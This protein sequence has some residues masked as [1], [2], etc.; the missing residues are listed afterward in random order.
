MLAIGAGAIRRL[1]R[2]AGPGFKMGRNF[3][4]RPLSLVNRL[5]SWLVQW[6]VARANKRKRLVVG[7][8]SLLPRALGGRCLIGRVELRAAV[9]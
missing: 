3:G 6:D 1:T 7:R 8:P 4:T 9:P 5:I 2:F